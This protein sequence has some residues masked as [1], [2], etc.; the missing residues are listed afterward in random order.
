MP[1]R[2]LIYAGMSYSRYIDENNIF[3]YGPTQRHIPAPKCLC[4]YNGESKAEERT[5][6]L[7]SSLYGGKEGDIEVRVTMLDINYGRNK[8]LLKAC[9]P[10][11]EYSWFVAK[12][13]CNQREMEF[14]DA[15]DRALDEMPEDYLIKPSLMANRA[16]VKDMCLTEYDEAKYTDQVRADGRAEGK[17][18]GKTEGTISTL[19]GLIK[20]GLISEDNAA[21]SAGMSLED[22][23]KAEALYC[24]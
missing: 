5:E 8:E 6:L 20:R 16:E 24:N 12:I 1:L 7:L 3:I 10:L 17:V 23:R 15:V 9:K 22:F 19:V 4:F 14:L 18:E 21:E 2:Y 13:R 11:A